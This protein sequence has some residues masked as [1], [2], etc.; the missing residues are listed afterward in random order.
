M[1]AQT[2][3]NIEKAAKVLLEAEATR[4]DRHPIIDDW[5]ELDLDTAYEAHILDVIAEL[6]ASDRPS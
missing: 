1:S 2:T 4:A 3:W 5:P 6:E